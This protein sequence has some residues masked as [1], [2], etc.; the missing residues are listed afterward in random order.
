VA[1]L[2]PTLPAPAAAPPARP[3]R[4]GWLLAVGLLDSFGMTLGWTVFSL[5]V[6]QA[7]GLAVLGVCNAA[8]LVGVAASA[9]ASG[10]LS[11][12]LDGRRLLRLTVAVE[13]SLRVASFALLL[14]GAPLPALLAVIVVM[15]TAGLTGYAAMR[16]E[17]SAVSRPERAGATMT[18]F[19]VAVSAVEA[20]G[21]ASAAL[22]PGTTGGTVLAVV[23][24]VYGLSQLPTWLVARDALVGKAQPAGR[25]DGRAS[26]GLPLVA[27]GLV[28]LLGSGP[29]L[30]A[31]GLV[32]ALYG[33]S[34]V[35][36]AAIAFTGGMLLAPATIAV[37][38]RLR[39]PA[40]VLWPVWGVGM[41][42]GWALAPFRLWGLLAA[43]VLAG[44]SIAAFEGSMDAH[45]AARSR[46]RLTRNLAASEA[47]RALGSAAAVALLPLLVDARQIGGLATA[48]G[49][50][51]LAAT[52]V[53][54]LVQ[55]LRMAGLVNTGPI[56]DWRGAPMRQ[57]MN[58]EQQIKD[59][60]QAMRRSRRHPRRR[61][62]VAV[63]TVLLVGGGMFVLGQQ[64]ARN[65]PP[66]PPATAVMIE[67]APV[68][69]TTQP[70][71]ATATR[72]PAPRTLR[73][74][75]RNIQSEAN[76]NRVYL[77]PGQVGVTQARRGQQPVFRVRRG[78][79]LR[80]RVDNQ[81]Q[82][83]HS[84]TFAPAKLNLDAWEGAVTARIFKAP[85]KPG[86]YQF[87]CRY[88]K[89]GMAGTLVVR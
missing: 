55:L 73:L 40:S 77:A 22:L 5:L 12:L 20:A 53:A 16:A 28:M 72:P 37:L 8:M 83:I 45:I 81:D 64:A 52:A 14:A 21:V 68:A 11:R 46:G 70:A 65:S 89:V 67:R 51:L 59:W 48:A 82:L 4:L 3:R 38:D 27:G 54:V 41:L 47:V 25:S 29:A 78:E 42:A 39:L 13:A 56:L 7:G 88:R 75:T 79:R 66:A 18:L 36:V 10:W 26:V 1:V 35:A 60:E 31:V 15:Y 69:P 33:T 61:R 30:L 44:L 23:V 24:A 6:L 62:A 74:V 17:V 87:Y 58:T 9:P 32:A 86:T 63:L 50:L 43:Q 19:V 84:F 57:E 49:G 76:P 85:S 34:W 71:P 2:A 80:I